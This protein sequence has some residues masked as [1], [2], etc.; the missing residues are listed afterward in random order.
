MLLPWKT[1]LNKKMN[2][3][4]HEREKTTLTKITL[5]FTGGGGGENRIAVNLRDW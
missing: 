4:A 5:E 2:E 1:A 3:K